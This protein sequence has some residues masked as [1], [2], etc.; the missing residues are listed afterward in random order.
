MDCHASVTGVNALAQEELNDEAEGDSGK[1][2]ANPYSRERPLDTVNRV[3]RQF[4]SPSVTACTAF[5][6]ALL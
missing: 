1:L 2:L 5:G 3:S 6:G 4:L